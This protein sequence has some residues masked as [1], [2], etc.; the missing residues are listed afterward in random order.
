MTILVVG[1]DRLGNIYDKLSNDGKAEIIHWKGR[2]SSCEKKCAIPKNVEKVIVF[3]DFINHNLMGHI[4]KQAKR[5]G[6]P[7]V[8]AR[9]AL[10]HLEMSLLA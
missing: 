8:Y 2:C 9:R 4:K 3:C 6:V 10:S 5:S 7:V 1:A